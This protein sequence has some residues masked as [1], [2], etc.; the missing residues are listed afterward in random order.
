[1]H[2]KPATSPANCGMS[3]SKK[4]SAMTDYENTRAAPGARESKL[5]IRAGKMSA[6]PGGLKAHHDDL[7][8]GC[9]LISKQPHGDGNSKREYEKLLQELEKILDNA[10]T[11]VEDR[12][13]SLR[14]DEPGPSRKSPPPSSM[15]DAL[16]VRIVKTEKEERRAFWMPIITAI[17]G[18]V[19]DALTGSMI[20]LFIATMFG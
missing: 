18:P 8:A 6:L 2:A 4:E 5:A 9:A 13:K 1:M 17:A 10:A 19:P 3:R 7:Q 12:A 14:T 16:N 11:L 15:Q 20:T